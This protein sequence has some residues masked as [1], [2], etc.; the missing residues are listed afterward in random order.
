ML[1]TAA[2]LCAV[3]SVAAAAQSL[4]VSSPTGFPAGGHPTYT[5]TITLDTSAGTPSKVTVALQPGVLASVAA[6]PGCVTGARQ[7]TAACQIGSGSAS[8][9]VPALAIPLT[10]YLVPPP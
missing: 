4:A 9:T 5:T 8:S 7:H 6:N 10:A 2:L 1:G 3:P